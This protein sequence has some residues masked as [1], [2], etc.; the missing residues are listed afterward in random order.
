MGIIKKGNALIVTD[1]KTLCDFMNESYHTMKTVHCYLA[2]KVTEPNTYFDENTYIGS[3][4]LKRKPLRLDREDIMNAVEK[5]SLYYIDDDK[6]KPISYSEIVILKNMLSVGSGILQI[7]DELQSANFTF[8]YRYRKVYR[9]NIPEDA[10][11][12]FFTE[13]HANNKVEINVANMPQWLF[14]EEERYY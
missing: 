3:M 6:D 11:I 14:D 4:V 13:Y 12:S 7:I 9:L 5:G 10:K 1:E 8:E 2:E